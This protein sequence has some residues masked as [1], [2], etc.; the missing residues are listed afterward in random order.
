MDK[1]FLTV[2]VAVA[3]YTDLRYRKIYNALTF[4]GV[5]LGLTIAYVT[6]GNDG[7]I[8]GVKGFTVGLFVLLPLF[9]LGGIGGGDVKLLATIGAIA[10]Y[11]FILWAIVNMA[12]I[13]GVMAVSAL[14]WQRQLAV[15]VKSAGLFIRSLSIFFL[16][17]EV[18]VYLP[19]SQMRIT[20]PYGVAIGLGALTA[21][22][23][24]I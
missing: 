22:F 9:R 23:I 10:G 24:R 14:V 1:L 19:E 17:P 12:L 8:A 7:F 4:P 5:L 21:L 20:L 11:P 3:V 6:G 13:G 16:T 18:G 15:S 2:V